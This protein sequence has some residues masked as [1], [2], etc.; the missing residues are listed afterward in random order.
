M[1]RE[2]IR[3]RRAKTG[4][5]YNLYLENGKMFFTKTEYFD[6]FVKDNGKETL[7]FVELPREDEPKPRL[8]R[9]GDVEYELTD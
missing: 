3:L 2:R 6:E 7:T 5:G 1:N 9:D 4:T 8:Q